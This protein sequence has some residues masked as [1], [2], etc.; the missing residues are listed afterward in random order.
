MFSGLGGLMI[1]PSQTMSTNREPWERTIILFPSSRLTWTSFPSFPAQ[2]GHIISSYQC[3]VKGS[4]VWDFGAKKVKSW[5]AFFSVFSALIHEDNWD[6]SRNRAKRGDIGK[7]SLSPGWYHETQLSSPPHAHG[8]TH[9]PLQ[10][11][12]ST[13]QICIMLNHEDLGLV[14]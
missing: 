13:K 1:I 6:D 8:Y 10:A 7:R 11:W 12:E 5:Y 9:P 2:R 14:L 4:E 3:N